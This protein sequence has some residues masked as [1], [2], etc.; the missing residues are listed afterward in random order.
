MMRRR[1]FPRCTRRLRLVERH[2]LP[3]ATQIPPPVVEVELER[4]REFVDARARHHLI[5][6]FPIRFATVATNL[7]T[8]ES[9]IFN[10]G[11][12]GREVRASSAA[13]GVLSPVPIGGRL[14]SHGQL[15][16]PIPVDA[17]RRLGARTVIAVDVQTGVGL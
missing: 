14:Y 8:G 7:A 12:V 3:A 10:A 11:D 6:Q 17:A 15:S 2:S 16:S 5:E 1:H 4:L 9:Q 13:P